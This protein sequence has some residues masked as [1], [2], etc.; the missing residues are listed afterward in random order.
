[1][2]WLILLCSYCNRVRGGLYDNDGL[3]GARWIAA[4]ILGLGVY[5]YTLNVCQAIVVFAGF[6]L[7][8]MKGWGLYFAAATGTWDITRRQ[9]RWIDELGYKLFPFIHGGKLPSNYMRGIF[10]M[11][12]RGGVFSIPLFAGLAFFNPVALLYWPVMFLQGFAYFAFAW[13]KNEDPT[14]YAEWL[15]GATLGYLIALSV[16]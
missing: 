7:W 3:S 4:A 6:Y 10:C 1:M 11:G 12:I 9:I 5:L 16:Y 13:V 8:A 14:A 15:W 2:I